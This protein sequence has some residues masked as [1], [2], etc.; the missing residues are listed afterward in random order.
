MTTLR[1]TSLVITHPDGPSCIPNAPVAGKRDD[2]AQIARFFEA[3]A[4]GVPPGLPGDVS[5][6]LHRGSTAAAAKA[7]YGTIALATCLANSV[8]EINGVP[9][10]ALAS[11]TE[12]IVNNEFTISGT[13]TADATQLSLAINNSTTAGIAG[14]VAA[15]NLIGTVTIASSV[16]GDW[17]QIDGVRFIAGGA[18]PS[19]TG[20]NITGTDTV[21]AASLVAA[22]NAHPY[23]QHKVVAS[24]AAGVITLRQKTGTTGLK[25]TAIGTTVALSDVTSGALTAN[26][27]VMVTARHRGAHGNGISLRT[28]GVVGTDAVTCTSVAATDTLVI[29]GTTFTAEQE[30]ATGTITAATAIAGN[31]CSI[32]GVTFTAKAGASGVGFP[33]GFSID[34][35]DTAT[36]TD[37]TTQINAHL[38]LSGVVTAT[39]TAGVVT[40]RAVTAGTAGNAITLTGTVTVLAASGATLANGA[41]VANN[42]WDISPG[43]TNAQGATDLARSINASTTALV[44]GQVRAIVRSNVVLIIALTPGLAGNTTAVSSTGGHA[45]VA[46]ARTAGGTETSYS[47]TAATGTIT[48]TSWPNT[49]IVTI[50][51]V[52]ITANTNTQANNQV[53]ISGSDTADAANLMLAINNSNSSALRKVL[54]TSSSNVVTVSARDG[55]VYG[56][57]ISLLSDDATAVCGAAFLTGGA[58]P[59]T[60]VLSGPRLTGGVGA[61]PSAGGVSYNF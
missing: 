36:A 21:A 24:N 7:A 29:N 35:S 19:T 43:G 37:L 59:T 26:T 22:I 50:N 2:L 55:G 3:C 16:A 56:N 51:G 46:T 20:Y 8:I 4:I 10:I 17:V 32:N 25:I 60:I 12:V 61:D 54:A 45:S 52:A 57:A 53:D 42:K 14:V 18:F 23:L 34:T 40:V 47:G 49:K 41:A 5:I 11:G 30:R 28:L 15:C 27:T 31:T 9:F 48:L 6:S 58:V 13:D 39:S 1:N 33:N 38:S 44:S